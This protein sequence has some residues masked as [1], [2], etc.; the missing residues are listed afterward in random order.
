MAPSI[1]CHFVREI[2]H[3]Q[4]SE[5]I[6]RSDYPPP[7]S[8]GDYVTHRRLTI[9]KCYLYLLMECTYKLY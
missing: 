7:P 3:L 1:I 6:N 5:I 4:S 9:K 2:K 8:L